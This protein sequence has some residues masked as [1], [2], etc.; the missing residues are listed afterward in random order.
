[1]WFTVCKYFFPYILLDFEQLS[2]RS[3]CKMIAHNPNFTHLSCTGFTFRRWTLEFIAINLKSLVE[4]RIDGE[5]VEL[6]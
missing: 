3:L 5:R 2:N 6:S 4:L 1:M